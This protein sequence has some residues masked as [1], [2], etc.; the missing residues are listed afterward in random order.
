MKSEIFRK[1]LQ[2]KMDNY[3]HLVYK[4]TK[5]FPS[6]ER[7]GATSQLRRSSLS[8]ILNF[9]EGFARNNDKVYNN[10]L[11]ISYGSLK[12]AQYLIDF[13]YKENYITENQYTTCFNSIDE[14]GKMLWTLI[15]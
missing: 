1:L 15:K 12:E 7:F 2:L 13:S 9:I 10:F 5:D 3:V 6:D 4:I 11:K 14:I 8:I